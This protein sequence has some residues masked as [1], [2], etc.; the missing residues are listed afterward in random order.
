[1]YVVYLLFKFAFI[2]QSHSLTNKSMKMQELPKL[3]IEYFFKYFYRTLSFLKALYKYY[4]IFT[5][6]I[7]TFIINFKY[8]KVLFIM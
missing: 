8:L 2:T 1:M 3:Y 6:I 4:I 5:H 7:Y